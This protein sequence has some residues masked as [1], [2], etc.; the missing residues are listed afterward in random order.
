M[1]ALPTK[2]QISPTD[3]LDLDERCALAHFLGKT[4]DAAAAMY[5]APANLQYIEDFEHM[6]ADGLAFYFPTVAPYLRDPRSIGDADFAGGLVTVVEMRLDHGDAEAAEPAMRA[7]LEIVDA[8]RD[9]FELDAETRAR[10]QRQ[11]ARL[12]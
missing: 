9:K 12:G 4:A 3:G 11:L 2:L 1:D 5:F 6:G 7:V 8:Q 10:L